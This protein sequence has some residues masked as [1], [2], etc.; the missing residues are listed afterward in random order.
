MCTG[1]PAILFGLPLGTPMGYPLSFPKYNNH[2]RDGS[3]K[4]K[5]MLATLASIYFH[6][7][8]VSI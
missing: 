2:G 8:R 6:A 7:H 1:L 5:V 4:I 3:E